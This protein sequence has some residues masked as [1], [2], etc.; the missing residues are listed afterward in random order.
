ME[1]Q[2]NYLIFRKPRTQAIHTLNN[3][4]VVTAISRQ[5]LDKEIKELEPRQKVKFNF[6]IPVVSGETISVTRKK[7]KILDLLKHAKNRGLYGQALISGAA[8]TEDY[9]MKSL[10]I[11]LINY[12]Q[13]ITLLG[14]EK[15]FDIDLLFN[16][17]SVAE[18]LKKIIIEK[19]NSLFYS[20]PA[21]YFKKIE[22]V[23][24]VKFPQE[25][26]KYFSEIKAT[27]D[28]VVH[29]GGIINS[30]YLLKSGALARGAEGEE[31]TLNLDYISD[32]FSYMK[33]IISTTCSQLLKKY[34]RQ[35]NLTLG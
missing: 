18:V 24:S 5:A 6:P 15:K 33:Q 32:A 11:I 17:S 7:P 30:L 27:R 35:I 21:E 19:V 34:R 28:I 14:K 1:K 31:I 22:E 20:S 9:L 12:P 16:S 25:A 26:V 4:Y 2:T 29:N 13:K 10:L 8:I 3:I 23:L